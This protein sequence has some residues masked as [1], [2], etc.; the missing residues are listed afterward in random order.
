MFFVGGSVIGVGVGVSGG[1]T[2][3]RAVVVGSVGRFVGL[4]FVGSIGGVTFVGVVV[5]VGVL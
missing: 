3:V 2:V 4:S 1:V 5:V